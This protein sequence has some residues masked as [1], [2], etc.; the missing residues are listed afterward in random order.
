M[1]T[2]MGRPRKAGNKDKFPYLYVDSRDGGYYVRHPVTGRSARLGTKD[3]T[4]AHELYRVTTVTWEDEVLRA[5]AARIADRIRGAAVTNN[6]MTVC[7][8]AAAFRE[9]LPQLRKRDGNN[10]SAK[11]ISDYA[12]MLAR[13]E[14]HDGFNIQIM[15]ASVEICRQFLAAW[16][17][18][19]PPYHNY[20]KALL[21]RMFQSAVDEGLARS[22]PIDAV[23]KTPVPKRLVLIGD[24]PYVS[25]T[26]KLQ[27]WEARACDL[28]FLIS[29]RPSDVLALTDKNISYYDRRGVRYVQITFTP[30]KNN[31]PMEIYEPV[32]GAIEETLQWFVNWKREQ[33]IVSQYIVVYP[34]SSRKRSIGKPLTTSYLSRK[35]TAAVVAAGFPRGAYK[36]RDLRKKGLNDEAV[37]AGRPT[38][39]GGHKTEQMKSHYVV[40]AIP[41]RARNHLKGLRR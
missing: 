5:Q 23:K 24:G 27:A 17:L 6:A 31:Q 28:L 37:M 2:Q 39:K 33:G 29:H 4:R 38:E 7:A 25:I 16:R 34:R 32:D 40:T 36:L 14:K 19:N 12:R 3:K 8:Y 9:K 10:L 41:K 11:T 20:M 18:G 30:S 35:F 13:V 26:E 22:N 1:T 15:D 21:A